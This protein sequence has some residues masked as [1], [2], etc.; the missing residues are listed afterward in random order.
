MTSPARVAWY[1]G[2]AGGLT[3]QMSSWG[4]FV[5]HTA[6][7]GEFLTALGETVWYDGD[8]L[9]LAVLGQK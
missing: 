8:R 4:S 5:C 3:I 1:R 9:N 6:V 2:T 7:L